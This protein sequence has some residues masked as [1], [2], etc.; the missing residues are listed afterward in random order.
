MSHLEDCMKGFS[1]NE[2]ARTAKAREYIDSSSVLSASDD[3]N[4]G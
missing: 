3:T 4:A 1:E 2:E